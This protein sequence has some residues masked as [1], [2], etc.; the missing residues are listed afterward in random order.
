MSENYTLHDVSEMLIEL[1]EAFKNKVPFSVTCLGDAEQIF[2]ACP[3]VATI[4]KMDT[5]LKV[6]GVDFSMTWLKEEI[7]E[8]IP[9]NDFIYTHRAENRE[10]DP[11]VGKID[12]A[13]FFYMYPKIFEHYN[14]TGLRLLVKLALRYGMV[15]N[16]SFFKAIEGAKV[17]LVGFH[18]PEVERLMKKKDF[19][20]YYKEM[21]LDKVEIVGSIG[22]SEFAKVGN[23]VKQMFEDTK[24]FD[25]DVAL[26]AM[27]IPSNWLGPKIKRE[28]KISIDIGHIMTALVGKGEVER[29][30]INEFTYKET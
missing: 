11:R 8:M 6:S 4:N 20:E 26:L 1:E 15:T 22:C 10:C 18:A 21:N 13:E 3:E 16:G 14:I 24:K 29:S 2:L 12:W 27:G 28:G 19:I 5:Y 30:Y 7:L 17:L 23:E 25:Y 9:E